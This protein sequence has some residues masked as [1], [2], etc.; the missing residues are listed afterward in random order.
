MAKLTIDN[1]ALH[2]ITLDAAD[3]FIPDIFIANAAD[4]Y[5]RGINLYVTKGGEALDLTGMKV[6]LL[7]HHNNGNQDVTPFEAVSESAGHFKVYYPPAMMYGGSVLARIAIY[8]GGE[9]PITGSRDFNIKV[10]SNPIN[11]DEA[12]TDE[13][14][15][16]FAD[17]VIALNELEEKL[18]ASEANRA[19]AE[20]T[21]E[22][23]EATR[24]SNETTRQANEQTRQNQEN[25]RQ[26][27]EATRQSSE[28]ERIDAELLR[29]QAELAR[30]KAESDRVAAE[31]E[32]VTAESQRIVEQAKN[33]AD[34]AANNLAAAQAAPHVCVSGEYD[35]KTH[36]P[37]ITATQ[38]GRIYLVPSGGT[39]D[40]KYIEW[41][42]LNDAWEQIGTSSG[43]E[44][45]YITTDQVDSVIDDSSPSG[46]TLLSLT[47]LSYLWARIKAWAS[48]TFRKAADL[49]KEGD[50]AANAI[51]NAK[52]SADSVTTDKIKN[53]TILFEDLN[54]AVQNRVTSLE[55]D[56]TSNKDKIGEL[57]T[58]WDSLTQVDY[59]E[60]NSN[61]DNC[62]RVGLYRCISDTAAT[63]ITNN[64]CKYAFWLYVQS[65]NP[66]TLYRTQ[67]LVPWKEEVVYIRNNI[68]NTSSNWTSWRKIPTVKNSL[69]QELFEETDP[70]T[71]DL[72]N[73][74]YGVV[75]AV[76][77]TKNI[78]VTN[79]YGVCFAFCRYGGT[80]NTR[81]TA[82][83]AVETTTNTQRW[84]VRTKTNE[85]A[86]LPWKQFVQL[87][88]LIYRIRMVGVMFAVLP[89]AVFRILYWTESL[90]TWSV[91]K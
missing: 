57:Q 28:K 75:S 54:S 17:A 64:P 27:Q 83:I 91:E 47:G 85:N 10:E 63:T 24:K 33:N 67:I 34:Q 70:G 29:V 65:I 73:H 7:W 88:S 53:G 25:T 3:Q 38:E 31:L 89:V 77:T 8:L 22:S 78:P 11:E 37:T 30:V 69:E 12:L 18:E 16:T 84:W 35:T 45:A 60:G 59:L 49:I 32:R 42:W 55:T 2:D 50:V 87:I 66:G 76:P 4:A 21:R 9:T 5:G 58:A 44:I 90:S 46:D 6:Y 51:T 39:G 71:A 13:N 41:M 23:N 86:F 74:F 43:G 56:N 79:F 1:W 26:S 36:K 62:T 61:L 48:V 80:E 14:F 52:L 15:R 82:Q 68:S 72:N 20:K 19:S 81:W 40:D